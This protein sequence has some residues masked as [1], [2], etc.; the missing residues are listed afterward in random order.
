MSHIVKIETKIRDVHAIR[1]AC[2]HLDLPTPIHDSHQLYNTTVTGWG[3]R[4]RDWHYP[5]V[6]MTN[7]G[8]VAYDNFGGRWGDAGRLDEFLQRYAVE[9]T[10]IEARRQGYSSTEQ[11]LENGSIKVT[12][13]VGEES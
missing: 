6:C 1:K 10:K 13:N 11:Q 3:V 7:S 5:V 12:I 9:K 2:S 8:E 4:L